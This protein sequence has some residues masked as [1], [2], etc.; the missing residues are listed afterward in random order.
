MEHFV[1]ALVW[2]IFSVH[3]VL[4]GTVYRATDTSPPALLPNNPVKWTASRMAFQIPLSAKEM[5]K[6]C[7]CW[8]T[9][10]N[11]C[12][13]QIR[14]M[15]QDTSWGKTICHWPTSWTLPH[16]ILKE[17]WISKYFPDRMAI[18]KRSCKIHT[19]FTSQNNRKLQ[20]IHAIIIQRYVHDYLLMYHCSSVKPFN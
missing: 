2:I 20:H 9:T 7:F 3:V 4:T 8:P 11:V 6:V 12:F 5:G 15:L 13:H 19:F 10:P 18:M 14:L 16:R 1:P 17:F